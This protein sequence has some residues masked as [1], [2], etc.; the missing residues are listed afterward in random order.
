MKEVLILGGA[1]F[2]GSH[3]ADVFSQNGY[4]CI[5]VDNLSKGNLKNIESVKNKV[6]YQIDI[7]NKKDLKEVFEKHNIEL[8]YHESAQISVTESIKDPYFDAKEN[9]MGLIN[10]LDLCVE[11][12]VKKLVFASSAAVYGVPSSE[13]SKE[14]DS[15]CALSFYG[16]TKKTGEE[17]IRL[18]HDIFGLDYVIFRY[19]NVFG[20]RQSVEGEAGVVAIFSNNM[21]NGQD[22]YIDGDG[23]QTR[24]FIYVKDVAYANYIAGIENIKNNTFNLSNNSKTSILEL[25]NIMKEAF[26]FKGKLIFREARKGDIRDSRLDN[27][28]LLENTSY[29][30]EY[31][32]KEGI[33]EYARSIECI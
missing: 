21:I 5:I 22:V 3:I 32:V 19:S 29:R 30:A 11:Y 23:L 24:D 13:I 27:T 20:P 33:N 12:K 1:G 9:I 6:F 17:Y 26:L 10:V 8:V 25:Y 14:N 4:K 18:Y 28:K 15:L 2:I 7:C 31:S 16:L